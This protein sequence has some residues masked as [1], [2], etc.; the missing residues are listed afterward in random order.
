M[1]LNDSA[2]QFLDRSLKGFNEGRTFRTFKELSLAAG[3]VYTIQ[4]VVPVPTLLQAATLG[5]ESSTVKLETLAGATAAGTYAETLPGIK[6]NL[7]VPTAYT[8]QVVMTAGGTATGGTVIDVVR[9]KADTNVGRATSI[10]N[11]DNEIRGIAVG[12]YFWRITNSG[13]DPLTGVFKAV[14]EE[15]RT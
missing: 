8:K 15:L 4:I 14:W 5:I 12:T 6:L 11:S 3:A 2:L 9:L 1:S 10:I 13:T 7:T